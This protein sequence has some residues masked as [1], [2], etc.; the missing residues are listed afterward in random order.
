M[1]STSFARV[2]SG[3]LPVVHAFDLSPTARLWWRAILWLHG[4]PT[5]PLLNA[6][7]R[8]GIVADG[9]RFYA[10]LYQFLGVLF[11]FVGAVLALSGVFPTSKDAIYWTGASVMAG[12]F[13]WL[14]SGLGFAGARSLRAN[15][16]AARAMLCAFMV[17]I[18]AFL[19]AFTAAV[20][21]TVQ[22]QTDHQA[23]LNLG[24]MA[25]VVAL[26][27]GSYLIEVI[28]LVADQPHASA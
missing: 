16:A 8:R 22:L 11:C 10:Q 24:I 4:K 13:L 21:L 20:S 27:I 15:H 9:F 12:V 28:Y 6:T 3:A 14:V 5:A 7:E 23:G 17:G 19:S 26:G 1:K 18:I 2:V 25:V